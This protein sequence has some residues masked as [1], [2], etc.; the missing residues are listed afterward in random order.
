MTARVGR[1]IG[2]FTS[3]VDE[4]LDMH[5]VSAHERLQADGT[6]VFVSEHLRWNR[7]R[8]ERPSRPRPTWTPV[9]AGQL[10]MFTRPAPSTPDDS[11]PRPA[12]DA[13]PSTD[14]EQVPLGL[15]PT[16]PSPR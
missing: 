2:L 12:D 8:T 16:R 5:L 10:S 9:P 3:D 11:P 1:Q 13:M 6:S 4:V 7:G 15:G 14:G